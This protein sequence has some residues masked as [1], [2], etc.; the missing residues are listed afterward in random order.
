MEIGFI[1]QRASCSCSVISGELLLSETVILSLWICS[2]EPLVGV[3][4]FCWHL[5]MLL[6]FS[7]ILRE[8]LAL[9]VYL[10]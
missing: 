5:G 2:A 3:G 10:Y 9:T 4:V 1:Y 7:E 8:Q 6:W